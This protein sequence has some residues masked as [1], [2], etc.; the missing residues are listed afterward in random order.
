MSTPMIEALDVEATPR[1]G[2]VARVLIAVVQFYRLAISPCLPPSCR[3]TPSC[4]A[5][6]ME[7]IQVHGAGRGSWLALRR[8]LRCHPFHAGGHDPVPPHVGGGEHI[9]LATPSRPAV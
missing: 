5:Y 4:S 8:L 3:Y 7:A 1:P 6:A 9:P 2:P